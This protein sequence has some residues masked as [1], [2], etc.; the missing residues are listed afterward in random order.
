MVNE[1]NGRG[2]RNADN[3]EDNEMRRK[4]IKESRRFRP[5]R[6]FQFSFDLVILDLQGSNAFF[7]WHM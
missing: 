5:K 4:V 7:T 6:N 2:S 1:A 3:Q